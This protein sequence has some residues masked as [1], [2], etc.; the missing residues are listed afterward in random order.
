MIEDSGRRRGFGKN[1]ALFH[2][3]LV[4]RNIILMPF[5]PQISGIDFA[6][7]KPQ[8][9]DEKNSNDEIAC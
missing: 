8:I 3:I 7:L 1:L 2:Q 4:V 5:K 9:L 6:N